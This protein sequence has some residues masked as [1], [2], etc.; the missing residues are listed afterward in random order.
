[1]SHTFTV[2]PT[3]FEGTDDSYSVGTRRPCILEGELIERCRAILHVDGIQSS[4]HDQRMVAEIF[5][6]SKLY[7]LLQRISTDRRVIGTE[8]GGELQLWREQWDYLFRTSPF[9]N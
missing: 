1:M 4:N 3:C 7:R 2:T 8:E 5:L 9:N 6:Y